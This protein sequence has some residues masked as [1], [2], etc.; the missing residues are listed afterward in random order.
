MVFLT[1]QLLI[2]TV[3]LTVNDDGFEDDGVCI[4]SDCSLVEAVRLAGIAAASDDVTILFDVP[5]GTTFFV[6]GLALPDGALAAFPITLDASGIAGSVPGRASVN[7]RGAANGQNALIISTTSDVTVRGVAFVNGENGLQ[8]SST[9]HNLIT[10]EDCFFGITT[11]GVVDQNDNSGFASFTEPLG[12]VSDIVIRRSN[13]SGNIGGGLFFQQVDTLTMEDVVVGVLPNGATVGNN[14]ASGILIKND[15]VGGAAPRFHITNTVAAGGHAGITVIGTGVEELTLVDVDVRECFDA[16]LFANNVSTTVQNSEF[17]NNPGVGINASGASFVASNV[18]VLNNGSTGLRVESTS[19]GGAISLAGLTATGNGENGLTVTTLT[20]VDLRDSRLGVDEDGVADGNGGNGAFFSSPDGAAVSLAITLTDVVV[21]ANVG[22][23]LEFASPAL[24]AGPQLALSLLRVNTGEAGD[25]VSAVGNDGSGCVITG[26]SVV[27]TDGVSA[28]NAS[29]NGVGGVLLNGVTSAVLQ[30]VRIGALSDGTPAG[31]TFAG[32]MTFGAGGPLDLANVAIVNTA[33]T[34]LL[35]DGSSPVTAFGLSVGVLDGASVAF[36]NSGVGV[37]VDDGSLDCTQCFIAGNGGVGLLALS[38]GGVLLDDSL[39]GRQPNAAVSP[40]PNGGAALQL[41]GPGAVT[42]TDTFLLGGGAAAV[43]EGDDDAGHLDL[44]NVR[45]EGPGVGVRANDFFSSAVLCHIATGYVPGPLSLINGSIG[46][47]D[48]L[49]VPC[50][51]D[52]GVAVNGAFFPSV[53]GQVTRIHTA[54]ITANDIAVDLRGLVGG[55]VEISGNLAAPTA[56]SSTSSTLSSLVFVAVTATGQV[57]LRDT[58]IAGLAGALSVDGSD[59][60]FDGAGVDIDRTTLD[61]EL[62]LVVDGAPGNGVVATVATT[63]LSLNLTTTHNA[64][65]GANLTLSGGVVHLTGAAADNGQAGWIMANDDDDSLL[66]LSSVSA[67]NNGSGGGG[68]GLLFSGSGE[69]HARDL[70]AHDNVG[71]GVEA[72][73]AVRLSQFVGA[74][75]GVIDLLF[76]REQAQA[77]LGGVFVDGLLVDETPLVFDHTQGVIVD[78]SAAVEL[79]P[80]ISMSNAPLGLDHN[81]DGRTKNDVG[82]VDGVLNSPFVARVDGLSSGGFLVS[83]FAAAGATLRFFLADRDSPLAA[84]FSFVGE[85]VEG[86]PDDLDDLVGDYDDPVEGADTG[87]QR[88]AFRFDDDTLPLTGIDALPLVAV[89]SLPLRGS[90]EPSTAFRLDLCLRLVAPGCVQVDAD[91]DGDGLSNEREVELGTNPNNG[92]TDGDG[93]GDLVESALDTDGDGFNDAIESNISDSDLDGIADQADAEV[94]PAGCAGGPVLRGPLAISDDDDARAFDDAGIVCVIGDLVIG[95]GE[96]LG[97]ALTTLRI[98]TGILEV[99]SSAGTLSFDALVETGGL[100][101]HDTRLGSIDFPALANVRVDVS[102]EQ[103]ALS[104]IALPDSVHIGG[105]LSITNNPSLTTLSLP[106]LSDVGGDVIISGNPLLNQLDLSSETSIGGDFVLSD[107]DALEE[108]L[109]PQLTSVGGDL[110]IVDNDALLAIGLPLLDSV[111]GDLLI[112]DNAGADVD[113]GSLTVV[114]G[115]LTITD[116]G[117]V[118][119]AP[120]LTQ[121][122]GELVIDTGV[123]AVLSGWVCGVDG[124]CTAV[125]GD[126]VLIDGEDCDDGGNDDGDGCSSLCGS[127]E[128]IDDGG[129]SVPQGCNCR[130]G[131]AALPGLL[132]VVLLA[133][134]RRRRTDS[135]SG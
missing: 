62:T 101:V 24:G 44:V 102:F 82:D 33:G 70:S 99:A 92:D 85:V 73:G 10:I 64:F 98:V 27:W 34:G 116:D 121:V 9:A 75:D 52:V 109:L 105:D 65:I 53:A 129:A 3:T 74:A 21:G 78:G 49:G 66:V 71:P 50:D 119:S 6:P 22:N 130:E 42:V 31:N 87:A 84:P 25:P 135:G 100:S 17:A 32:V 56:F 48:A 37:S 67:N 29:V 26:G 120:V 77:Q 103:N 132:A 23:G 117:G 113:L 81:G 91:S 80:N 45:I 16:G 90:S 61:G 8:V 12:T 54:S 14:L 94:L 5:L 57:I 128:P 55:N 93:L 123:P 111:G 96:S 104:T 20:P 133:L 43:I 15:G 2:A 76:V 125:C 51:V 18:K 47:A 95:G 4:A 88:F 112:Q 68:G 118:V 38:A 72:F 19:P 35:M 124:S 58:T 28:G 108:L 89:A 131:S 41:S 69:V 59:G 30:G 115:D 106:S 39:V 97:M 13:A 1:M 36:G 134:P 83:G 46:G 11:T 122:G 63:A 107:A 114:G 40:L 7:V 79:L 110:I 86:G 127:E 126:G 60:G